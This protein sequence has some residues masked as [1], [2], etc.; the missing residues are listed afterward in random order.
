MIF[1]YDTSRLPRISILSHSI[2]A[3][4]LLQEVRHRLVDARRVV[5]KQWKQAL[6]DTR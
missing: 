6:K 1:N 3:K 2:S 5:K 4:F